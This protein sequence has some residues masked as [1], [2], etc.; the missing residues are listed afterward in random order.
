M[1]E[2]WKTYV[3]SFLIG[4]NVSPDTIEKYYLEKI[5]CNSTRKADSFPLWVIRSC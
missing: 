3:I 5:S 1:L 4:L 2:N